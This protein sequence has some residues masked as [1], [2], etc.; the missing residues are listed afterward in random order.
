MRRTCSVGEERNLHINYSLQNLSPQ[1]FCGHNNSLKTPSYLSKYYFRKSPS[2][3]YSVTFKAI[4]TTLHILC[5]SKLSP[6]FSKKTLWP[7]LATHT[8]SFSS[9]HNFSLGSNLSSDQSLLQNFFVVL[10]AR[11]MTA[12]FRLCRLGLICK[13]GRRQCVSWNFFSSYAERPNVLPKSAA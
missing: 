4:S 2:Q 5:P 3:Y 7:S 12:I 13:I 8:S 6:L 10:C 1:N 11:S 9:N